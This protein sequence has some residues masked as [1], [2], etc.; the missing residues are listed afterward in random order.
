MD[1]AEGRG[2]T[3]VALTAAIWKDAGIPPEA[4]RTRNTLLAHLRRM[5]DLVLIREDWTP[6]FRYRVKRG[7]AWRRI[8]NAH[9]KGGKV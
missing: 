7:P 8:E 9:R 4:K 5:P 3:E 6:Y 1:M 2:E